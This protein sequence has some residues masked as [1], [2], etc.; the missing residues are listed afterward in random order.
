MKVC[1]ALAQT[2]STFLQWLK[3]GGVTLCIDVLL[4]FFVLDCKKFCFLCNCEFFEV[5]LLL[6]CLN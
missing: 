5:K 1:F 3:T 4:I 2:A 6:I